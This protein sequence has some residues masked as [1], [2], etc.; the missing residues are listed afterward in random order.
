MTHLGI[1]DTNASIF[2]HSLAQHRL[3]VLVDLY[4]LLLHPAGLSPRSPGPLWPRCPLDECPAKLRPRSASSIQV[5]RP[6]PAPADHPNP[7][8]GPLSSSIHSAVS[9]R[10]RPPPLP[11]PAPA[12]ARSRPMPCAERGPKGRSEERRVRKECRSR[13]R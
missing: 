11:A 6:P 8:P 4:I 7:G 10:P 12:G 9:L 3:P 13:G 2:G 5:L 1:F